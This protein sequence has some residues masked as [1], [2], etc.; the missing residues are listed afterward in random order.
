[1]DIDIFIDMYSLARLLLRW[2]SVH[3]IGIVMSG[4]PCSLLV[5]RP[6]EKKYLQRSK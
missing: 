1:L 3:P 5:Y 6:M 4:R 2:M